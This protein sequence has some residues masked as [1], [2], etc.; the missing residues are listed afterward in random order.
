MVYRLSE[1][2]NVEEILHHAERLEKEYDWL[3]AA[4]S[5]KKAL[6][7][8]SEDFS[9]KGDIT[10][11]L[12]HTFYRFAFQ[13]ENN[14]EFR[15]RMRQ[16]VANYQKV[17]EFYGK[18]NEQA[19]G[20]K[21]FRCDAM[22]A[23]TGYWLASQASEKKRL[24]DDCWRLTKEALKSLDETGSPLEY[25]VTYNQL[26]SSA[27]ERYC[28][29][30]SFQHREELIREAL[31]Y[32]ERAVNLL[33]KV[34]AP[35][36]LAKAYVKTALC[37]SNFAW[38]HVSDMDEKEGYLRKGLGYWQKAK[39][40][41]EE[42][43]FLELLSMPRET[44]DWS[45]DEIL[46]Q[47]RKALEHARKTEDRYLVGVALEL[48]K[49]AT[50]WT[51]QSLE[52]PDKIR[53]TT[54]ELLQ[55]A[56]D[57]THQFSL[58]SYTSP[59][60]VAWSGAP[61][62]VYYRWL[63]FYETDL[64]KKRDLLEKAMTEYTTAVK[65]V[66]GT[67]YPDLVMTMHH[68]LGWC[69]VSLAKT[70]TNLEEKKKLLESADEHIKEDLKLR[71][72]LERFNY[73]NLGVS[74]QH[75]ADL[76]SE[77]SE[78]ETDDEKKRNM[79]E[80]AVSY[81][82]RGVQ[83]CT[84]FN[85][86]MQKKEDL[87]NTG[88]LGRRQYI[89]GERL[90]LLYGLTHNDE[91]QRKALKAFEDS[92]ESFQKVN[93]VS[94]VAES[95]WKVARS[96]DALGEH[97]KA[98]EN[99]NLATDNYKRA[100]EKIPQLKDLYQDHA[101]YMEA[102][103]AIEKA[104]HHHAE[105]HYGQAKEHYEKAANLHKLTTRWNY[106]SP[107]YLA[108]AKLEEGEDL[109]RREQTE[110][111]KDL[112]QQAAKLFAEAKKSIQTKLETIENKG[113][114]EL[115]AN[116]AHASDIREEYCLGRIALEEAKILDKQGDHAASSRKYGSATEK[117]QKATDTMKDESDRQELKPI[118]YLCQAWQTMTR[119]E[120]EAS[121][122][123]YKEASKLFEEAK[124][125][126]LDEKAKML[127]LGHSSFC[128][129]LEA[130]TRF[131]A[132]RDPYLHT[133]ATQHLEGA[134]SY[135]LKAGFKNASEYAEATQ[136]LLDA[137]LYMHNAKTQT[138]PTKKTQFYMMAEKVLQASAGSYLKAKHPEKQEQVSSLLEKV[139]NEREL[140]LSLT[141]VLHAP[142]AT[143]TTATFTT[144]T[145]T[146][147]TSTGLEQFDHAD[148][149]ANITIRQKELKV[150][151]N[152]N[153]K[154]ELVN[155]GKGPALLIKLAEAIPEGFE[156]AEKPEVYRVEDSYLDMKGK[157]LAPLKTEELRLILKPKVQGTFAFKP[158]IFYLD[159]NGKYK[160]YEPESI[161]I[162]VK[163]L[164]IKGWIKGER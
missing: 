28:F 132:V 85:S 39:K 139:K 70:E 83:L 19:R 21:T 130:G 96:Y 3:G 17:K 127:A 74:W 103:N 100:A 120:A 97:L 158:T 136:K 116:L 53:E 59:Y 88:D 6:D 68:N 134:A 13:A 1:A 141:E 54:E 14:D 91:V 94:R 9:R 5:Y 145:P 153:L 102:W 126:S 133:L 10:E 147:E 20:P 101:S 76:R 32:G 38:C 118:V 143:S 26:S 57:I 80:E 89:Y 154:V 34:N 48:L 163:E 72:E 87:S 115:L 137:Y 29:E 105:K 156:L 46:V 75:Q 155:A 111:A 58:I 129:A 78:L 18:L 12:G 15:E 162:T 98:A 8:L 60:Y 56:K 63:A 43:A 2:L 31:Q 128:K 138:D 16:S 62:A 117:F 93:L 7:L 108:W 37:L 82:E 99:F 135:Y 33:S 11:R 122:D 152:L 36:E 55:Y 149:Q 90:D 144:P 24:L 159:E 119:A 81:Q 64:T 109:S 151:E 49:Y 77:L 107:N 79:L 92:A 22:I 121:P 112:F 161:N 104:R 146:E 50:Y 164:G 52:D 86:Y 44:L 142:L 125:H 73:W 4:E 66:E 23:F 150:G 95:C 84:K 35:H 71:E 69:L 114:K 27:C 157:R 106:L 123:L 45:T 51:Q 47:Y 113:E 61:Y 41:S 110:E 67:G 140:A 131:E 160:S 42:T 30:S 148:I 25:G 65:K 124:D 40:L